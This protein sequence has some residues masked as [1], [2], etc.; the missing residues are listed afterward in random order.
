MNGVGLVETAN[1]AV[2]ASAGTVTGLAGRAAAALLM[3]NKTDGNSR[4]WRRGIQY[5]GAARAGAARER[6]RGDGHAADERLRH[7]CIAELSK[8]PTQPRSA[9]VDRR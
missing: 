6:S 8:G 3:L 1:V 2:V 4:R 7:E 9:A 5:D